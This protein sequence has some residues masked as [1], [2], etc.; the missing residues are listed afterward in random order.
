M[1]NGEVVGNDRTRTV[2]RL[3][4]YRIWQK[5]ISEQYNFQL[6]K[7][8]NLVNK[9]HLLKEGEHEENRVNLRN[10]YVVCLICKLILQA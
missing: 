6:K 5:R 1:T 4:N 3:M 10:L 9:N 7:V 2:V 8:S